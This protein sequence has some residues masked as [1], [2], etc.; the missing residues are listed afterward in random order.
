MDL[1]IGRTPF[2]AV[3]VSGF[4]C[5]PSG[6]E[7][8]VASW[9]RGT[10]QPRGFVNV[11][12]RYPNG[13]TTSMDEELA[14]RVDPAADGGLHLACQSTS[15]GAGDDTWKAEW[16]YWA[17]PLP[18]PGE[19]LFICDWPAAGIDHHVVRHSTRPLLDAARR[20]QTL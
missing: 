15:S 7:F 1:V 3:V 2:A 4:R 6:F 16:R 20:A 5:Y 10:P 18:G 13:T 17:S 14:S 12:L 8:S 9:R 11:S 19:L